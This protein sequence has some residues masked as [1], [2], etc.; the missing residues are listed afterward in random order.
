MNIQLLKPTLLLVLF[1]F[2]SYVFILIFYDGY[3][4]IYNKANAQWTIGSE[5]PYSAFVEKGRKLVFNEFFEELETLND[6]NFMEGNA[7]ARHKFRWFYK[8]VEG[9]VP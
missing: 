1:L 4:A 3:R 5:I 6:R 9:A 2:L 7:N 8:S